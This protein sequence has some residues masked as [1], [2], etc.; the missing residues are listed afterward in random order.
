MRSERGEVRYVSKNGIEL[1][2]YPNSSIHSFQLSLYLRSGSMHE[3][4]ERE[5]GIAHFFEHVAIRN[6]N[7]MRNGTLYSELDRLGVEFNATTY[8]ELTQFY[9]GGAPKN[10]DF[11]TGVL[12]DVLSP[13]ILSKREIDEER[14]RIKAEIRESDERTSLGLFTQSIVHG[15]TSLAHSIAGV[16]KSLNKL[17]KLTLEEYRRRSLVVGNFFFYATGNVTEENVSH[18]LDMLDRLTVPTGKVNSNIAPVPGDFLKRETKVYIKN[19]DYTMARFTFDV[20]M[21]TIT[22]AE[23]DLVYDAILSGYN[24][25]FFIELSEKRGMLYDVSG[26]F[27]RYGGSGTLSFS[28]EIKE[29]ELYEAAE[30]VADVLLRMK[31]ELLPE[32]KCMRAVYVDNAYMLLDDARELN[33]TFAYDNHIMNAGYGSIEDRCNAYRAVSPE[34]IRELSRLIFNTSGLTFTM[35]GSKKRIDV[36]RILKA[37]CKIDG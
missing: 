24:S 18:L 35:K 21:N 13:I 8:S 29:S 4:E 22:L 23:G 14:S 37:L 10:F 27:E 33:F 36:P 5:H 32:E 28:F 31:R 3:V 34:R 20:D 17:T 25:E 16:P 19:A 2:V 15:N 6:V 1:F 9:V 26:S 7:R 30:V 12:L 11:A